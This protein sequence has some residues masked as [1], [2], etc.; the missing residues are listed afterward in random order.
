MTLNEKLK[1]EIVEIITRRINLPHYRIF[2]FGSRA[3]GKATERSDIDI[4]IE[5]AE[6]IPVGLIPGIKEELDNLPVLQKI[7]LVDFRGVSDGFKEVA[8]QKVEVL[9]EK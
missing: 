6:M 9:Y 7:D 5:S 1:K 3:S 8:K 4:G 2:I